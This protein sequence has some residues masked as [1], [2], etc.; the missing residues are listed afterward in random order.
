M[1]LVGSRWV[2]LVALVAVSV[3]AGAMRL[4]FTAPPRAIR[5]T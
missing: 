3:A 2:L 1:T 5:S 4:R